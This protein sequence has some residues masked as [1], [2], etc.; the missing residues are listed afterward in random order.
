MSLNPLILIKTL[1]YHMTETMTVPL[2]KQ[3]TTCKDVKI[4]FIFGRMPKILG[5]PYCVR[6]ILFQKVSSGTQCGAERTFEIASLGCKQ[7]Q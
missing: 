5:E 2:I 7:N 3:C 4:V 1:E 6:C